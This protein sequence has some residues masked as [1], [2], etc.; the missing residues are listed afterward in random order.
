MTPTP[1]K[2]PSKREEP[3]DPDK[4]PRRK[5][6]SPE[7]RRSEIIRKASEFFAEEGFERSTRELAQKMGVTQPLLY[8]YFPSKEDLV[9]EVYRSVFLNRWNPEWDELLGDRSLPLS[10]SAA[11]TAAPSR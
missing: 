2:R 4:P 11:R 5:R 9:R 10:H 1:K 3:G 7:E 6:L 8:R